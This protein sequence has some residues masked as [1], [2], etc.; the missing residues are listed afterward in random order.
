[1]PNKYYEFVLVALVIQHAMRLRHVILSSVARL[2][3]PY[4]SRYIVK[5]TTLE[6][7]V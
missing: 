1:M 5:G 2:T 3:V 7:N 6:K 4:L